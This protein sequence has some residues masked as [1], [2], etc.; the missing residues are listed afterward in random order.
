MT[1]GEIQ[2]GIEFTRE[3]DQAKAEEIEHWA[4]RVAATYNVLPMDAASFRIWARLMHRR[5]NTLY[6][7][8]M[9]AATAK[10]HK[11]IV[12]TRNVRIVPT[13]V[14][15]EPAQWL[16]REAG[17]EQADQVLAYTQKCIVA[18]LDTRLALLAA[19]LHRQHRLATADAI[20]YATARAHGAEL[21][22]CDAHFAK[23]A[24]VLYFNK[25]AAT[26]S[27]E[28]IEQQGALCPA[29]QASMRPGAPVRAAQFMGHG[30]Q[31]AVARPQPGAAGERCGHQQVHVHVSD[32]LAVQLVAVDVAENLVGFGHRGHWEIL[33]QLQAGSTGFQA[34]T[35]DLTHHE[36]MP[37]DGASFEQGCKPGVARAQV[38]DPHRGVDEDQGVSDAEVRSASRVG[39]P[40]TGPVAWR[41]RARSAP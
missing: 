16:L 35:G 21:L 6:E 26:A 33:Q 40:P 27:G 30:V 29:A 15:L 4:D 36:R 31:P 39:C 11:L 1:L 8:A 34:A 28:A 18:P 41:S 3:Q 19:E 10:R 38:F 14:Q 24:A 17:E 23:L 7:D 5:S 25:R 20:V 2:A 12:A 22:T 32:A 9:I 13:I 37:D